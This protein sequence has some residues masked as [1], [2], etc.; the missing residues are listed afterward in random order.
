MEN[1]TIALFCCLDDFAKLFEPQFWIR[2]PEHQAVIPRSLLII[3]APLAVVPAFAGIH[4]A[5]PEET[6]DPTVLDF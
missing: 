6:L 4:G 5:T 3:P 2:G 1:S